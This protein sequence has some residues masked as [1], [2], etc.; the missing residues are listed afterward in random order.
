[1][2]CRMTDSE[3]EYEDVLEELF[4]RALAWDSYV[5]VI[6]S[7]KNDMDGI[8]LFDSRRDSV[9]GELKGSCVFQHLARIGSTNGLFHIYFFASVASQD[10]LWRLCGSS[11]GW[12]PTGPDFFGY[13]TL[14]KFYWHEVPMAG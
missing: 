7:G 1:M 11:E 5:R 9:D 3:Y 13:N 12:E 14:R 4:R 2:R 6:V 8:I 10:Y